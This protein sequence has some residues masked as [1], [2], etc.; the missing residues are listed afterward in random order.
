MPPFPSSPPF[1]SLF[2]LFISVDYLLSKIDVVNQKV[3]KRHLEGG[4]HVVTIATNGQEAVEYTR[5][6]R[7]DLIFMDVGMLREGEEEERGGRERGR[8]WVK[9]VVIYVIFSEMPVMGGLEATKVIRRE[10]MRLGK[11]KIPIIGLSGISPSPLPS[12]HP[13]LC[14]SPADHLTRLSTHPSL[15]PPP[16]LSP[17]LHLSPPSPASLS[18]PCIPL[19]SLHP[20]LPS[21]SP[22]SPSLPSITLLTLPQATHAKSTCARRSRL[23]CRVTS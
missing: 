17:H 7:F 9:G 15:S 18:L 2:L 3:L 8:G 21:L 1:S 10:E 23:G 14:S 22:P 19:S 5:Q 6:Q 12:L 16:S 13:L 4:H 11:T 20:P